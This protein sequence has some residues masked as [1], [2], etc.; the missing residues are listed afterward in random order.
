MEQPLGFLE[1]PSIHDASV[2]QMTQTAWSGRRH[3]TPS[4]FPRSLRRRPRL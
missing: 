4:K 3:T 1:W 2:E